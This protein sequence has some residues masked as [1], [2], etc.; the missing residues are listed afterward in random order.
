MRIALATLGCRLN[1][2]ETEAIRHRLAC[3]GHE[4]QVA[5]DCPAD[6]YVLNSCTVTA[7]AEAKGRGL[8]RA[9]KRRCPQARVLVVGCSPQRDGAAW[10]ALPEVHAVLGNEEKKHLDVLLA[11][12]LEGDR[13]VHVAPYPRKLALAAEWV[14]S[15][16]DASRP[17]LKV[18]EGCDQRCAFCSVRLARGPSRSRPPRAVVEQALALAQRGSRELVLA[19]VQLGAWGRDLRPRLCLADLVEALLESLPETVRLRLSSLD[20]GELDDRL[21]ELLV[22]RPRVTP[23]LHVALQ[24]GSDRVLRA[25]RRG[26]RAAE[27]AERVGRAAAGRPGLGVGADLLVGFPGE[28]EAAFQETLSLLEGLPVSFYHVFR[29]SPRPGTAGVGQPGQ[30]APAVAAGRARRLLELG[31]GRREAFYRAQVG[32]TADGIVEQGADP[33]GRRPVLLDDYATVWTAA[34]EHLRRQRV[35]VRALEVDRRG[36]LL[37]ELADRGL[38]RG[39][40]PD[41]GERRG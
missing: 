6:V 27:A 35:R 3:A 12:V 4:A 30:V 7:E 28:D 23:Y 21:L 24:S 34:P 37:G 19:G 25:M 39:A 1:Q 20:P 41:L 9:A 2:F 14:E 31:R 15:A 26:Y 33:E 5:W 16:G 22:E 13:A 11:A 38:H 29:Y 36:R 8:V 40:D 17:V 18:Q 32:R 10:L